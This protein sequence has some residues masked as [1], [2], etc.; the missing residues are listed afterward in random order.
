VIPGSW[1]SNMVFNGGY[2]I[3]TNNIW[4]AG[5][6]ELFLMV[7]YNMSVYLE[8]IYSICLNLDVVYTIKYPFSRSKNLKKIL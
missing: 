3:N 5:G 1:M 7:I 2:L 4:L 6:S 8:T